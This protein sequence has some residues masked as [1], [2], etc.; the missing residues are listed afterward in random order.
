MTQ[1]NRFPG[2]PIRHGGRPGRVCVCACVDVVDAVEAVE[3]VLDRVCVCVHVC[4]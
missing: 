4:C 1:Y 3:V 2:G